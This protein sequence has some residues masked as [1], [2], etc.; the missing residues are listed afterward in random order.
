MQEQDPCICGRRQ[1]RWLI[2]TLVISLAG[3]L[4]FFALP[5]EDLPEEEKPRARI[6]LGLRSQPPR[7]D[8]Q[9]LRQ[10]P[11]SAVQTSR[12]TAAARHQPD[13]LANEPTHTDTGTVMRNKVAKPEAAQ[14]GKN[15]PSSAPTSPEKRAAAVT[16]TFGK[17]SPHPSPT[18]L[19]PA[20]APEAKATTDPWIQPSPAGGVASTPR[21]TTIAPAYLDN[22]RPTYPPL[23]R[24]RGWQGDV[25]IRVSVDVSGK[26]IGTR[27]EQSS[28]HRILDR[29][30]MKQI[31]SWRFRPA[32]REGTNV[33]GEV[34][35]PVHF[36]LRRS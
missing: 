25:L 9:P 12:P 26:V 16:E 34:T 10:S 5:G 7:A 24:Q 31:R 23:A 2:M 33:A 22:P 17:P 21:A 30:A 4:F 28:G 8:S 35:V 1:A 32:S 13:P 6:L 36:R 20:A 27:L 15:Q 3:H 11:S 14:F 18:G 29:S 19:E